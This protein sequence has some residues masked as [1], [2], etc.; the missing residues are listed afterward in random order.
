MGEQVT[1]DAKLGP[2][3]YVVVEVPGGTVGADG[4]REL[5]ALVE[6][7]AIRVLDL[8]IR[9]ARSGWWC[10]HDRA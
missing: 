4:F 3:D 6:R 7:N 10:A 9:H 5:L 1:F 8:E 2:I